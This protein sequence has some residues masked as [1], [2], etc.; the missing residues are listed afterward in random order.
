MGVDAELGPVTL[1]AGGA[2][3]LDECTLWA[4]AWQPGLLWGSL[5][6]VMTSSEGT[7]TS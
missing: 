7:A 4:L 3:W 2:L 5:F 6:Y 1:A